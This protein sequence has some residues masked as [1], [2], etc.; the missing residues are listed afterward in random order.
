[1]KKV[2][3]FAGLILVVILATGGASASEA[4]FWE[5]YTASYLEKFGEDKYAIKTAPL[6]AEGYTASYLEKFGEDKY[7]IKIKPL[8]REGYIARYLEKFG[9]DRFRNAMEPFNWNTY[10]SDYF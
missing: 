9:E 6:D 7:A 8:D 5:E 10:P 2:I 1:M 3:I 4:S